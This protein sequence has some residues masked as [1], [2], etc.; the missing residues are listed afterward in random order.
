MLIHCPHCKSRVHASD[1]AQMER[2]NPEEDPFPSS[3]ILGNCPSC[4]N[5]LVGL[6]EQV[7]DP[8][9]RLIWTH[10]TRLWPEP[11]RAVSSSVPEIVKVSL[12]EADKC[13]EAGAYSACAVMCGRSLEGMCI[14]FKTEKRNLSDGLKALKEREI[15]DER[16][17]KWGEELRHIRNLGA[18]ATTEKVTI[19]DARDL[20]HFVHAISDY[21]FVLTE[22]FDEFMNRKVKKGSKGITLP[23]LSP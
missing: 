8:E 2:Y 12:E 3:V 1:E 21:V 5:I 6:S 7:D 19:Q 13:F 18:H 22:R 17:Y 20:L 15:I 10:A 11:K 23:C 9:G 4:N 16:L 14:H